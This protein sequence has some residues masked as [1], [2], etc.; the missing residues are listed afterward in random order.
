MTEPE[1][2]QIILL[3]AAAIIEK[4]GW[5]T[6]SL[7][8]GGKH[9]AVGAINKAAG[10]ISKRHHTSKAIT[11]L[12]EAVKSDLHGS[13]HFDGDN[14]HERRSNVMTWNDLVAKSGKKVV[15]TMRKAAGCPDVK[16]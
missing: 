13:F 9:C 1:Q 11:K 16:A 8:R 3:K 15:K 5:I 7:H 14:L 6:G 10:L 2:W 12:H 4:E